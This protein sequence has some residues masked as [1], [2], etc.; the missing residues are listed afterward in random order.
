MFV[1]DRMH[2]HFFLIFSFCRIIV[3]PRIAIPIITE[4][5]L[6][7]MGVGNTLASITRILSIPWTLEETRR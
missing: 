1:C 5:G 6:P 3:A 2:H 4:L 7:E